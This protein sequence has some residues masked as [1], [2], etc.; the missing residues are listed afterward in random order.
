M[1]A[2]KDVFPRCTACSPSGQRCWRAPGH[3]A[4]GIHHLVLKVGET[5]TESQIIGIAKARRDVSPILLGI[6]LGSEVRG[7]DM[8][9]RLHA[10]LKAGGVATVA[11]GAEVLLMEI[12]AFTERETALREGAELRTV[13]DA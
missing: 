3:A 4:L 5:P 2:P 1:S 11:N 13:G 12:A 9:E 6:V 10:F 7:S 8:A